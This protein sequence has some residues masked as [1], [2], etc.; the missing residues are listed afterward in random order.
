MRIWVVAAVICS[1]LLAIG[2]T[3]IFGLS[4]V[5]SHPAAHDVSASPVRDAV[6][7]RDPGFDR[8]RYAH[9]NSTAERVD[10]GRVERVGDDLSF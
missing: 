9:P 4:L 3:V 6:V 7:R 10:R 1:S 2:A 5:S 8:P